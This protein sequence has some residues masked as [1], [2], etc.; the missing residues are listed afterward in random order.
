MKRLDV[1][2]SVEIMSLGEESLGTI[3]DQIDDLITKYGKDAFLT[4]EDDE[5]VGFIWSVEFYRKETD[6]EF[7]ARKKQ[8]EVNRKRKKKEDEYKLYL[9]LKDKF[10]K[11]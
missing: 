8:I 3:S 10:E 1:P 2:D 9:S 7:N 5:W 6:K 11:E 4:V